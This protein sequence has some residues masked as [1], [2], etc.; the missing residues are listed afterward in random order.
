MTATPEMVR[1]INGSTAADEVIQPFIDTAVCMV[2]LIIANG[3]YKN[4]ACRDQ[5]E[6]YIA[7]HLM[8]KSGAGQA[9]TPVV[10]VE[11]KFEN[12]SVKTDNSASSGSG[13]LA[14][15]YGQTANLLTNGCLWRL[16]VG[17]ADVCFF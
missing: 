8:A 11:E 13:I 5:V 4:T 16:E 2:D 12:Y 9:G 1:K 15:G 3:C 6:A 10:K 14:T 7:A 17:N